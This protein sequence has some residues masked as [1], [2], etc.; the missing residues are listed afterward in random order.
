MTRL[1]LSVVPVHPSPS[2][3]S[4][5]ESAGLASAPRVEA[6]QD[7]HRLGAHTP[8]PPRRWPPF[9]PVRDSAH[10]PVAF[11]PFSSFASPPPSTWC[12]RV[13]RGGGSLAVCSFGKLPAGPRQVVAGPRRRSAS[14]PG[15]GPPRARPALPAAPGHAQ[16]R[17]RPA[18]RI[19]P[20]L[21]PQPPPQG[22]LIRPCPVLAVGPPV[23]LLHL[24]KAHFRAPSCCSVV[25]SGARPE[26][27]FP[28][29]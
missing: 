23:M 11:V 19:C 5:P 28:R 25:P 13:G 16:A 26:H 12:R 15:P 17:P 18:A 2:R 14:A 20:S 24:P 22:A 3:S 4:L 27:R 8:G 10:S 9:R 7:R 1:P 21:V 6:V 29:A